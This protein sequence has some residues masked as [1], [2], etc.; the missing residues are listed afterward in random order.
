MFGSRLQKLTAASLTLSMAV[1]LSWQQAMPENLASSPSKSNPTAGAA[2][3]GSASL[4]APTMQQAAKAR[5]AFT[6]GTHALRTEDSTQAMRWFAEALRLDPGNA[7]YRTAYDL[8]TQ[9]RVGS[10]IQAAT[11]DVKQGKS[12]AAK[13]ELQQALR[14]DPG[15]P[16]VEEHV[17]SLTAEQEP[18]V[19]ASKPMPQFSSGV[20][21]LSPASIRSTFHIRANAQQVLR[22][23]YSSYGITA[24]LDDSVSTKQVRFD[25]TSASFA[26]AST[27]VQLST[28]TFIVPLDPEHVLVAKDTK[29]NRDKFERLMLETIFLP[30]LDAKEM[31]NAVKLVRNVF[32]VKQVASHKQGT[33]SIRAPQNTLRAIDATLDQLYLDQPEVILDVR[34]YQV[35]NSRQENLGAAF[36][37]QLSVFNVNSQVSG[38]IN[39][40]AS[41]IAQLI[42]S[43]LVNP[44]DLAGIVALLVGLGLV[45]GTVLNQPFALFGNGLTLSGLSFGSTTAN[46]SLNISNTREIDHIQ[47]RTEDGKKQSFL[48]GQRYPVAT[49][50]Y[51]SALQ[52]PTT[53]PSLA[54][55]LAGNSGITGAGA[56]SPL[57]MT[58]TIDYQNIGMTLDAQPLVLQSKD[59]QM[60]LQ[61]KLSS[62]SGNTVNGSP[63]INN[64]SFTTTIQVPNGGSALIASSISRSE[65]NSLSGIPGLS[66]LPGFAWTASPVTQLTVNQLL[67]VI[68][69]HIVSATHNRVA[70]QMISLLS[71]SPAN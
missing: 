40:N 62:L 70:S 50:T 1:L 16:Y 61:V 57:A 23:V 31:S 24:I 11:H 5:E 69:P 30:G 10:L 46:A 37:Q 19:V 13:R 49:Q 28:G 59:V 12:D 18:A 29:A 26:Q 51:S 65:S 44:G 39:S 71:Q 25:L 7:A 56:I 3:P 42:S 14:V 53:S 17:S 67:I 32:G 68:S 8:A 20:V 64:R 63:I 43:G 27:A 54:G 22:Q 41:T 45:N 47:L 21:A 15:N 48:I 52:T 34:V 4:P 38:I 55:L 66:E 58:P 9:Q 60:Q 33:L 2:A 35:S 6:K 36:P